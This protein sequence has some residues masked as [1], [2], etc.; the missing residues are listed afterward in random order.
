MMKQGDCE[1]HDAWYG[2][3]RILC[4]DLKVVGR[5]DWKEGCRR[6]PETLLEMHGPV[7]LQNLGLQ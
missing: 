3:Q 5:V 6:T 4:T 1:A 7:R 2:A